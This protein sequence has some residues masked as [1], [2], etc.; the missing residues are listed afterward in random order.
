MCR[1]HRRAPTLHVQRDTGNHRRSIAFVVESPA[2][3]AMNQ[4]RN[5]DVVIGNLQNLWGPSAAKCSEACGLEVYL[6]NAQHVKNV[7]GRK[8]DVS[9]CQWLPTSHRLGHIETVFDSSTQE[10]PN[11][12]QLSETGYLRLPQIIGNALTPSLVLTKEEVRHSTRSSIVPGT[13]ENDLI[14]PGGEEDYR[15]PIFD[16]EMLRARL[17]PTD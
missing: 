5:Q 13:R 14:L 12:V 2:S 10:K 4:E 17:Y 16:E 9:D 7:P 11:M 15:L 8:T 3:V 1:R 6:V